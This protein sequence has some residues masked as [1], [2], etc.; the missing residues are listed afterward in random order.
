MFFEFFHPFFCGFN[1]K[2]K[3]K[4]HFPYSSL[5]QEVL[6]RG[7]SSRL[8]MLPIWY[9]RR[10]LSWPYPSLSQ[11]SEPRNKELLPHTSVH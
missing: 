10:G 11:A 2:K 8:I 1:L 9:E 6:I 3:K 7:Y 5:I 4:V